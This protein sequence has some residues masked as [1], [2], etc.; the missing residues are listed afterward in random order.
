MILPGVKEWPLDIPSTHSLFLQN[1]N[2][3]V[4]KGS[5]FRAAAAELNAF[6]NGVHNGQAGH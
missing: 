5:P 3:M 4:H 6:A 2:T 1:I